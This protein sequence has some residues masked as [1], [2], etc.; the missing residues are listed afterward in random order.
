MHDSGL[1]ERQE[2]HVHVVI[3]YPF[4]AV[5]SFQRSAAAGAVC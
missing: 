4:S 3:V 2:A 5:E 1:S